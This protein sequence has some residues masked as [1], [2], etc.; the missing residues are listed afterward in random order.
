[1]ERQ[2]I[3]FNSGHGLAVFVVGMIGIIA[4]AWALPLLVPEPGWLPVFIL[5]LL[6]AVLIMVSFRVD[7]RFGRKPRSK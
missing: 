4:C 6:S 2:Y 1:M 3:F 7:A 5:G